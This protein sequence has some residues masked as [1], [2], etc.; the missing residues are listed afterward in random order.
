M[1]YITIAFIHVLCI[2]SVFFMPVTYVLPSIV[3]GYLIAGVG[4]SVGLH[5]Y[6]T[7]QS[8]TT[9]KPFHYLLFLLSCI[10][11]LGSPMEW[12][13]VHRKHH[14][15]SDKEGDPHSPSIY[16]WKTFFLYFFPA[17][18]RDVE[19]KYAGKMIKDK[20]HLFVFRYYFL[21]LAA[22]VGGI[23]LIDPLLLYPLYVFPVLWTIFGIGCSIYFAHRGGANN[24]M[25]T[26][27][28][29]G[30]EGL[31]DLHHQNPASLEHMG[32]SGFIAKLIRR[33]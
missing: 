21:I 19:P 26:H 24:N 3:S 23:A 29:T 33:K 4:L 30:G 8:F 15:F 10:V 5:K 14:R 13:A 2:A 9:Y 6:F 18:T 20:E 27:I 16:G 25:L 28:M 12:A 7:H 1:R 22:Y 31:H 11:T 17:G 32:M